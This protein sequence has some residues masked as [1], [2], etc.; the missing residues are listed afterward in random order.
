MAVGV[1]NSYLPHTLAPIDPSYGRIRMNKTSWGTNE[2][3]VRSSTGVVELNLHTCGE[4]EIGLSGHDHKFWPI[5]KAQENMF[6]DYFHLYL[7]PDQSDL[8]I[9]GQLGM[10]RAQVIYIDIV[11]C[12]GDQI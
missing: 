2:N 12:S 9:Y 4:E 6:N 11:K 8:E 3:G 5:N 7:C 10:D 1:F